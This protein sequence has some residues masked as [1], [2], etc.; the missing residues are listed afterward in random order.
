MKQNFADELNR[1]D[2][3]LHAEIF[4]L[5]LPPL[6][7][8]EPEIKEVIPDGALVPAERGW[9]YRQFELTSVGVQIDENTRE[10]DWVDLGNAL[11]KLE[12]ASQWLIGDWLNFG[13]RKYKKTYK[14]I[15]KKTGYDE[16]SLYQ[17]V[18]VC[19]KF[20]FSIRIENLFFGHHQLVAGKPREE[21]LYW[22]ERAAVGK[23]TI[24]QMRKEM[25]PKPPTPPTPEQIT[26]SEIRD[27]TSD[28]MGRVAKVRHDPALRRELRDLLEGALRMLDVWDEGG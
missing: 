18:W 11:F 1:D 16:N 22:L 13:E 28:F 10:E 25:K 20:D 21:A 3:N 2:D 12:S 17:F 8:R 19:R 7:P 4:D 5:D 23:W 27:Q 14:E 24:S 15:A 26:M 6:P 9:L